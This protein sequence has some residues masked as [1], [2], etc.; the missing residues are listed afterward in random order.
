MHD[1]YAAAGKCQ[2]GC[3]CPA[4]KATCLPGLAC[5]STAVVLA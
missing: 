2:L 3:F 4:K 1:W 5:H